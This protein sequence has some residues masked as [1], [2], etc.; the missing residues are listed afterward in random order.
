MNSPSAHPSG[1]VYRWSGLASLVVPTRVPF[2][3]DVGV[4]S[5]EPVARSDLLRLVD[6]HLEKGSLYFRTLDNAGQRG[7]HIHTKCSC[8]NRNIVRQVVIAVKCYV[9]R[10]VGDRQAAEGCKQQSKS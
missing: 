7:K 1:I 9:V 3:Y 6:F 10:S 8:A 5:Y 2:L 4:R